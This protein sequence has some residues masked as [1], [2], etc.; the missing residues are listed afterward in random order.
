MKRLLELQQPDGGWGWHG[1][2]KTHEMMTPYALYGLLAGR[3]GGLPVPEPEHDSERDG[4]ARSSTCDEMGQRGTT[5]PAAGDE[6]RFAACQRRPVLPVGVRS[7]RR[8]KLRPRSRGGFG[9]RRRSAR[10]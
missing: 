7:R 4:T 6:R 3:E 2:G 8:T 5:L 10:R 1:N 9:S